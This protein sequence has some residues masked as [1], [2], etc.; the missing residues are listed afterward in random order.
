MERWR[1]TRGGSTPGAIWGFAMTSWTGQS[2]NSDLVDLAE[3]R[4]S[5]CAAPEGCFF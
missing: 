2:Q 4:T 5:L 1:Q 3:H